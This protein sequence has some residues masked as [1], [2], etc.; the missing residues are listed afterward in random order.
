MAQ[1]G[2]LSANPQL[3]MDC[4][5]QADSRVDKCRAELTRT[6]EASLSSVPW[7]ETIQH[8]RGEAGEWKFL[9]STKEEIQNVK[10][11]GQVIYPLSSS[12]VRL[13]GRD[14]VSSR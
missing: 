13:A 10:H 4:P 14:L 1:P 8:V 12:L 2:Q 5:E 3:S 6:Q 9:V 11:A 7:C